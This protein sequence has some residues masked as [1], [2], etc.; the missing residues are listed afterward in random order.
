MVVQ[1]GSFFLDIATGEFHHVITHTH[2][3]LNWECDKP[4]Q[5]GRFLWLACIPKDFHQEDWFFGNL[6]L[7]NKYLQTR[8]H[9]PN[10]LALDTEKNIV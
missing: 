4:A 2:T 8:N 7:Y 5:E 6:T 10:A 3:D 1:Q 9:N